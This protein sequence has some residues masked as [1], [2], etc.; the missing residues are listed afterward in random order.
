MILTLAKVILTALAVLH[1]KI[2]NCRIPT[3]LMGIATSKQHPDKLQS[4]QGLVEHRRVQ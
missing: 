1:R 2:A 3:I 4:A